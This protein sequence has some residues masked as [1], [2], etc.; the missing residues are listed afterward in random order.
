V[1]RG[2][3]QRA[4]R[5]S[6]GLVAVGLAVCALFLTVDLA[7]TPSVTQSGSGQQIAERE[8][9]PGGRLW[10]PPTTVPQAAPPQRVAPSRE[11]GA[12]VPNRVVIDVLGIDV[13][14]LP[15]HLE[16][17]TLVPP[18][19]PQTLG[20]WADGAVPGAK[21]GSAI[22]TGHTVHTGGG[23]L[24]NLEAL[25]PGDVFTVRTDAGGIDYRVRR[26][27]VYGKERVSRAS[28]R[29]FSQGVRGRV[30]LITCEDWDGTGYDSNVV[31]IARPL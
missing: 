11:P 22:I 23:A 14:V 16:V 19:D 4:G 9:P 6:L 2:R 27:E 1:P 24:D 13:P 5:A 26:V 30:V 20:W 7:T 8:A 15:I 21:R 18:S 25:V 10:A 17:S 28:P 31:V 3:A 12:G 29:L